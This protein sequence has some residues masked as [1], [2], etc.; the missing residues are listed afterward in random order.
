MKYSVVSD[1]LIRIIKDCMEVDPISKLPLFNGRKF[2]EEWF[3]IYGK[4]YLFTFKNHLGITDLQYAELYALVRQ[5]TTIDVEH[6]ISA[7]DILF[8]GSFDF[9]KTLQASVDSYIDGYSA[10]SEINWDAFTEIYNTL[11]N[12]SVI[13]D[14][15]YCSCS[16]L[17]PPTL[18]LKL[19]QICIQSGYI[20]SCGLQIYAKRIEKVQSNILVRKLIS[21]LEKRKSKKAS[22]NRPKKIKFKVWAHENSSANENNGKGIE[23]LK[24]YLHKVKLGKLKIST[25]VDDQII[26][27]PL[28]NAQLV[29]NLENEENTD[30]IIWIIQDRS[31]DYHLGHNYPGNKRFLICFHQIYKNC[32]PL[33]I[34]NENKPA[35]VAPITIP[36]SLLGAMVN[37]T[38]PWRNAKTHIHD[39]FCGTGSLILE[40]LKDESVIATGSDLAVET[41]FLLQDNI[42]YLSDASQFVSN[43][44][45]LNDVKD[46]NLLDI[47]KFIGEKQNLSFTGI[48]DSLTKGKLKKALQLFLQILEDSNYD[49]KSGATPEYEFKNCLEELQQFSVQERLFFYI[50]LRAQKNKVDENDTNIA[51]SKHFINEATVLADQFKVYKNWFVTQK[52][53]GE[54]PDLPMN[55]IRQDHHISM[56]LSVSPQAFSSS[57]IND[58]VENKDAAIS[59]NFEDDA[60][61]VVVTDP[62]YG[63]NTDEAAV[64]LAKM[65]ASFI[66]VWLKKIKPKGHL[67]ICLPQETY[68]GQILPYCTNASLIT[69]MVI[70]AAA[71]IKRQIILP[72]KVMPSYSPGLAPPYY[73]ISDKVLKRVVL[74]F[75]VDVI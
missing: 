10:V 62:P 59:E 18:F 9:K 3:Y 26:N 12:S 34:F 31:V 56:R 54:G 53:N 23:T 22:N 73:W 7:H 41:N 50:A 66:K 15:R 37:I 35:W 75:Q 28:L 5:Y 21:Y 19:S 44:H 74:Y 36:H 71:E 38:R 33:H 61:D 8:H 60:Y 67:V 57:N 45:D 39:P 65:Y 58:A 25:V 16:I 40:M 68:N 2:F 69:S 47:N 1:E 32:N 6:K 72:A 29:F 13:L 42:K 4:A 11:L 17:L 30:G 27:N 52:F 48:G 64:V 63:F 49:S 70:S 43:L 51:F 55:L 46:F 14:A 20:D 24:I